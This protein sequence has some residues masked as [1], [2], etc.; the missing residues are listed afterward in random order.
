MRITCAYTLCACSLCSRGGCRTHT[1]ACTRT[2]MH[3]YVRA[4]AHTHS[5]R[6]S[7]GTGIVGADPSGPV[8]PMSPKPSCGPEYMRTHARTHVRTH[9]HTR[10]HAR[11]YTRTHAR[12]HARAHFAVG[13]AYLSA[14]PSRSPRRPS[15]TN[16]TEPR[17][18]PCA[19]RMRMTCA[20]AVRAYGGGA[21]GRSVACEL[22]RHVEWV[23][24][25]RTG[26][27]FRTACKHSRRT[28][29]GRGRHCQPRRLDERRTKSSWVEK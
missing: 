1:R 3:T 29:R 12:T 22:T 2:H 9:T 19:S 28:M 17:N 26:E 7:Q 27:I 20:Y 5:G 13:T 6:A 4:H 11:T 14:E 16:R 23:I 18:Q 8:F 24:T 10:A 21:D 25:R 15:R